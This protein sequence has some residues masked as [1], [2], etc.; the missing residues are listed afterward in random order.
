MIQSLATASS[1]NANA[2]VLEAI[3]GNAAND[4]SQQQQSQQQIV[5]NSATAI[6]NAS[7]VTSKNFKKELKNR[8]EKVG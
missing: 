4:L 3:N 5:D 1:S 8:F 6:T 2:L 7:V